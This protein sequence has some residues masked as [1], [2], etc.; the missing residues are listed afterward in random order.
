[1]RGFYRTGHYH[2][3]DEGDFFGLYPEA[4]YGPNLDIYNGEILGI[5]MDGKGVLKGL[6]AA[7]GPQLWWGANPTA[8]LKYSRNFGKWGITGIYHRDLNTDIKIDPETG[9]R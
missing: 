3:G 4:N 9:R 5:E 7:F 1:M 8:L 2:W 6:K